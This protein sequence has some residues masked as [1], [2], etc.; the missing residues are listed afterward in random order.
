MKTLVTALAVALATPAL[1][2]KTD[3]VIPGAL[4]GP[5][6]GIISFPTPTIGVEAKLG[7]WIGLSFDYGFVP[8]IT[9]SNV[10][11]SW[12]NWC[13]GAKV[14]PFQGSL[15]VGALYGHRSFNGSSVDTTGRKSTAD[16]SSNY[17]AP[18][19]GWRWIWDS[20][21]YMGIDLGWQFVTS[22]TKTV[23]IPSGFDPQKQKDINDATDKLGTAGL[24][25]L[26]LL[27]LGFY[28]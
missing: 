1:A 18:E 19:L 13:A 22:N 6:L 8:D 15:F 12:N 24:P 11:V 2:E 3:G 17:I 9:I 7:R 16:A 21:F 10:T 28:F 27:Q 26:G 23:V 20:G 4:I 14:F 25:V 5:K